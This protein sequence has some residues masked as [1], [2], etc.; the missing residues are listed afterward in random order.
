MKLD[1]DAMRNYWMPFT[2]NRDFKTDP[3]V[4]VRGEGCYVW[5]HDGRKI[6]DGSS[7]LFCCAAGHSRPEIAEAVY[8]QL[9][10]LSYAPPFQVAV[11]IIDS[12]FEPFPATD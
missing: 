6:L 10:E 3:R 11:M 9:K 12:R 4:M 8:E 2:G 1:Q 7:G 5:S